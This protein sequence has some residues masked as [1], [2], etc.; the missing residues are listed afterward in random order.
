M[1][2]AEKIRGVLD[3]YE[4]ASER[5][6]ELRDAAEELAGRPPE[7]TMIGVDIGPYYLRLRRGTVRE[8]IEK[9]LVEAEERVKTLHATIERMGRGIGEGS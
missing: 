5:Q 7:V 8:A 6:K 3:E 1:G 2:M 4:K 9:E